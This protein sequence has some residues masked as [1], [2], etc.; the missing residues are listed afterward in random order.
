MINQYYTK[1]KLYGNPP[2]A[3]LYSQEKREWVGLDLQQFRPDP[4]LYLKKNIEYTATYS[5]GKYSINK[6]KI[7][8]VN[9][10]VTN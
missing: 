10:I 6:M 3:L 2:Y 8:N 1:V 9:Y 7:K 4:K 5:R